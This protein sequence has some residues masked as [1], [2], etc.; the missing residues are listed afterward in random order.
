MECSPISIPAKTFTDDQSMGV[1]PFFK[2]NVMGR[3]VYN[4]K[5]QIISTIESNSFAKIK[6]AQNLQKE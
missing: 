4:G 5:Y 1:S 2:Q 3:T 6:L